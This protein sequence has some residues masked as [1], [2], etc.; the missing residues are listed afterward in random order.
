[1]IRRGPLLQ[2][3]RRLRISAKVS[4]A[5]V[6]IVV[7]QGVLSLIGVSI[8]ITQTNAASLRGQLDRT[9]HSVQS[10]IDS[11]RSDL[12][13]KANLLAGQQKIIDYTDY[14]LRNLLQQELSVMRLPLKADALVIVNQKLEPIAGNGDR[15]LLTSFRTQNLAA[16]W[17]DG[18]TLFITPYVGEI[19]LWALSPI[20]R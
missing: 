11:A 1:M 5:A 3:V 9:T 19:H 10:F 7:F 14:D 17:A 12:A 16:N 13:V 8:L 2:R 18:N 4:A 20:V 6:I 15:R